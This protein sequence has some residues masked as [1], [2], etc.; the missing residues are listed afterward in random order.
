HRLARDMLRTLNEFFEDPLL[1]LG[2]LSRQYIVDA[3]VDIFDTD[4]TFTDDDRTQMA[5]FLARNY[6]KYTQFLR[7]LE[8]Q[9]ALV[10]TTLLASPPGPDVELALQLVLAVY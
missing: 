8:S 3:L 10:V 4:N 7:L 6:P 1:N 2:R 5:V 9:L